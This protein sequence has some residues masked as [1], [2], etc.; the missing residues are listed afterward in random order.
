[1]LAAALGLGVV[2][3][4]LGV[5]LDVTQA[6]W[7]GKL[8]HWLAAFGGVTLAWLGLLAALAVPVAAWA[9][10]LGLGLT[11]AAARGEGGWSPAAAG[12]AAAE[13]LETL[14]RLLVST[15]SFAR[16]GAFALAHA[17][18]S[19]AVVGVADAIGGPG[20]WVALLLGNL[21]ILALEGL[22][23]GIQTTRLILF[24]FFIRFFHAEGRE[25]RPLPAPR[26]LINQGSSS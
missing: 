13:F 3:L 9:V 2:L 4:L 7:H 24:E 22:V 8:W 23:T 26:P 18:L 20:F 16:V 21:L 1:V 11:L 12:K 14:M 17:G 25:F 6:A 10:P 19:A 15:V 5:G